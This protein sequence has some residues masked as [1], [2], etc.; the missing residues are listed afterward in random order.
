ML[1]QSHASTAELVLHQSRLLAE[2]CCTT[3]QALYFEIVKKSPCLRLFPS[4]DEEML[5]RYNKVAG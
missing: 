1:G 3:I 5:L 4:L 2:G